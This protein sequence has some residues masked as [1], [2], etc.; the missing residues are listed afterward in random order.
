MPQLAGPLGAL[1]AQVP[2]V[3]PLGMVHEPVQQSPFAAHAS[4]ACTQNEEA[5]QVPPE[6]SPEQQAPSVA[7]ALPMVLHA[8]LSGVH[9][10]LVPQVW[11]QHCALAVQARLSDWQLG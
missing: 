2:M 10:P 5:W 3:W 1:A 6:Q 4:P 9:V 11:L 8:P 7:H